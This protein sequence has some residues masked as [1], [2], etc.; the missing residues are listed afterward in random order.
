M[1]SYVWSVAAGDDGSFLFYAVPS[2]SRNSAAAYQRQSS[3]STG[4]SAFIW[5]PSGS[6]DVAARYAFYASL[7]SPL[8][9]RLLDV[10]A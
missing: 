1:D 9:G 3:L 7:N 8:S 4:S 5:N 10:Y 6:G 2:D